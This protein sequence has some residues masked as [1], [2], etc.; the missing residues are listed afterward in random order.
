MLQ[1]TCTSLSYVR[2]PVA[3][4]VCVSVEVSFVGLFVQRLL[5]IICLLF[6]AV[7]AADRSVS[8]G[9]LCS[10]C[11]QSYVCISLL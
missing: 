11:C 5:P 1:I 2:G 7:C 4:D 9:R 8:G 6:A 3:V 10:G